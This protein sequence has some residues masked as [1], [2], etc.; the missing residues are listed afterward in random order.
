MKQLT[1][2]PFKSDSDGDVAFHNLSGKTSRSS[3]VYAHVVESPAPVTNRLTT[4][5]SSF[6]HLP[7]HFPHDSVFL[8]SLDDLENGCQLGQ[9]SDMPS[10]TATVAMRNGRHRGF[11]G[12]PALKSFSVPRGSSKVKAAD[13]AATL[14]SSTS[15]CCPSIHNTN[16]ATKFQPVIGLY[17]RTKGHDCIKCLSRSQTK[18]IFRGS[19]SL[20]CKAS[21]QSCSDGLVH[22]RACD[23]YRFRFQKSV[24]KVS[25]AVLLEL[26]SFYKPLDITGML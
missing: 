19:S 13:G 10:M 2:E 9:S 16:N 17:G 18:T 24:T 25:H 6:A 5:Q 26:S 15:D 3:I 23:A 20:T 8:Y 7:Q 22:S 1:L 4:L 12:R 14:N 21:S 11:R